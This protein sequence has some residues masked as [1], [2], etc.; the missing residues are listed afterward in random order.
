MRARL[1]PPDGHY[2]FDDY[3]EDDGIGAYRSWSARPGR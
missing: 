2:A 3:M 1:K